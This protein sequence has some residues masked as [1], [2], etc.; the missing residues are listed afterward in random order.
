MSY[1]GTYLGCDLGTHIILHLGKR[2]KYHRV[3]NHVL[4]NC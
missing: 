1:Q 2:L 3:A 4:P